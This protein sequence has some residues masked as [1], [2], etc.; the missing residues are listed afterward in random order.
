MC[1]EVLGT[2]A[3][4]AYLFDTFEVLGQ[5]SLVLTQ[6]V[7]YL[8]DQLVK[9]HFHNGKVIFELLHDLIPDVVIDKQ[10]VLLLSKGLT[11]DLALLQSDVALVCDHALPLRQHQNEYLRLVQRNAQLLHRKAIVDLQ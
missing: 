6:V 1:E 10:L 3:L 5:L 2:Q 8:F 7:L 9:E 4:V 11:V